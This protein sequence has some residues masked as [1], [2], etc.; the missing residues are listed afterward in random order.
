MC[1]RGQSCRAS[2]F[3]RHTWDPGAGAVVTRS[4][5][6]I[7]MPTTSS[8]AS[9]AAVSLFIA[10]AV[11]LV[12]QVCRIRF[13]GE[14]TDCLPVGRR[15]T[16]VVIGAPIADGPTFAAFLETHGVNVHDVASVLFFTRGLRS[17]FGGALISHLSSAPLISD[18]PFR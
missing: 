8:V 5:I 6:A 7:V 2:F 18:M 12:H 9:D 14:L 3:V 4:A 10:T 15:L 16:V 13:L 11:E 1:R 17:F